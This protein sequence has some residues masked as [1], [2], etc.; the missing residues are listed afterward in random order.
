MS[1]ININNNTIDCSTSKNSEI[2]NNILRG[3]TMLDKG[4][5]RLM[6]DNY[7]NRSQYPEQFFTVESLIFTM[8]GWISDYKMF[9]GTENFSVLLG[10]LLAEL[11]EMIVKLTNVIVPENGKKQ[12]SKKQKGTTL[13]S[14]QSSFEEI[15]DKIAT[16]IASLEQIKTDMSIQIE[17]FVQQEFEKYCTE[18][19]RKEIKVSTRGEKTI[20]FPF[21]DP[22]K[23]DDLVSSPK[24]FREKV[25][26][27]LS[28][29]HQTG[30]KKT[31]NNKNKSYSLIGFRS[32]ARKA[33]KKNGKKQEYQIRMGKCN[34][35]GE[36]FSFLPSFLPREKHFEI[37]IIGLV[38]RNVLLFNNSIRS[39][40]ETMKEFCGIKS[41]ETI[42][43]WLRWIG[44]LHP[45]K[46]LTRAGITGSGYLHEDEG[47][48][49]EVDMRTYSVAMVEPGSM[50]VWHADYVD[51]VDEKELTKSFEKFL[52]QIQFK[53]I[54]VS[55]DKWKASTNALKKVVKGIWIG[56]CH[57][58]CKK[59]IWESLEKYQK[60]TGC[61]DKTVKELYKEF[62]LI[63]DQSTSKTNMMVRINK[64]EKR[65]ECNHQLLKSRIKELKKNAAHYTMHKKRK[66]ITPTTFAVDN[67]LKIVKRKLRQVESFRDADMT[68]LTFQGMATVRNFVPFMSGAKNAHKSPFELAGGETYGLPWI[69]TM[70][71]HNSFL[72]TPTAF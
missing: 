36:K 31:C 25:L 8:R 23:Y 53:V 38:V 61:P 16:G 65:E 58:H 1:E 51:R 37:D 22:E 67:Y 11:F 50:L 40:F 27:N 62:K 14:F 3:L 39:I 26:E 70:N 42:F 64:L 59:N 18:A 33:K 32:I 10:L 21:S 12:K 29:D 57:R 6:R 45:A 19:N 54:G 44:N 17:K 56:F 66:G 49:K 69:Q 55:K 4:L 35:C 52:E 34:D 2:L 72:F 13:K 63:L 15:L 24:L 43:N 47:F 60:E 71:V 68:K 7:Y 41:K 30:H 20:I 5:N 28:P 48:E 46:L 9:S